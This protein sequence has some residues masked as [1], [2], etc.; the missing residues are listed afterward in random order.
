MKKTTTTLLAA[1]LLALLP[2]RGLAGL[3]LEE[4]AA[5][6]ALWPAQVSLRV[7]TKATVLKDGQPGG[8]MLLGAGKIIVVL[9][10]SAEGVTGRS[11]GV[12]VR[13]PADATTLF[14]EVGKVHPEHATAKQQEVAR[15]V[16]PLMAELKKAAGPA[17][18]R[19]EP[20]PVRAAPPWSGEI[21]PIQRLLAGRLVHLESG[22]LKGFDARQLNGI[23]FYGIMFSA[24]WCGPCR[25]F[26]P[27]LLDNYHKLRTQYPEFELV[28]VSADRSAAEML[29]YMNEEHMPWPALKFSAR[30]ELEEIARLAG[31]GI[32]CLVLIDANGKVLAHSFKGSD[33]LGPASVLDATWRILRK[34]R[35]G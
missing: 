18:P 32:P 1:G 26:A 2:L 29:A 19:P 24:G 5:Q 10:V 11:G 7:A 34:S 6:S 35:R 12:T 3:T 8:M 20:A 22:G 16:A 14:W 25:E 23:K 28:L 21:T 31:P 30:D 4:L 33:Y 27:D 15:Q 9:E 13:V 17:V